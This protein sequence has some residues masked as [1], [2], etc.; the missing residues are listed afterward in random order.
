MVLLV[1]EVPLLFYSERRPSFPHIS[2]FSPHLRIL[3]L[4]L[5][6]A[7]L[8]GR[9]RRR[10]DEAGGDDQRDHDARRWDLRGGGSRGGGGGGAGFGVFCDWPVVSVSVSMYVTIRIRTSRVWS[11]GLARVLEHYRIDR[12][13]SIYYI[14]RQ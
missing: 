11:L 10:H 14:D 13:R 2:G 6:V 8:H 12:S 9:R 3:I 1:L 5:R 4:Q 7:R